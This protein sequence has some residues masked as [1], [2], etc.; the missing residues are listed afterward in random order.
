[1]LGIQTLG[2]PGFLIASAN[3]Q[4]LGLPSD[5]VIESVAVA[6]T[7]N[8]WAPSGQPLQADADDPALWTGTL[9]VASPGVIEVKFTINAAWDFNVGAASTSEDA[10]PVLPIEADGASNGRNI[11]FVADAPGAYYV[12]LQTETLTYAVRRLQ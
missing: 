1:G 2:K 5:L 12:S 6:G 8:N 4:A 10:A 9:Q 7:F 11:S 3:E